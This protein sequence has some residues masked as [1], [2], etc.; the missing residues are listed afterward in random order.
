MTLGRAPYFLV[1]LLF[2]A[3][4]AGEKLSTRFEK[5]FNESIEGFFGYRDLKPEY[6]AEVRALAKQLDIKHEIIIKDMSAYA[7]QIFGWRNAF[8]FFNHIFISEFFFQEL[9]PDE[10]RFLLAHELAHIKLNHSRIF[11]GAHVAAFVLQLGGCAYLFKN[12]LHS[13]GLRVPLLIGS[14]IARRLS[15]A[16]IRRRCE[17]EADILAAHFLKETRGGVA[18]LKRMIEAEQNHAEQSHLMRIL[19]EYLASHPSL[20]ERIEYLQALANIDDLGDSNGVVAK[21]A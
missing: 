20:K 18:F 7:L 9:P 19:E 15:I 1:L 10:R 2:N 3:T 21:A 16:A 12:Y 5:Y 14:E 13:W 17:R 6:E 8:A 4:Y 11:T